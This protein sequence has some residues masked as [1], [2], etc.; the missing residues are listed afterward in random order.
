MSIDLSASFD[1][2]SLEDLESLA[3]VISMEAIS[4]SSLTFDAKRRFDQFMTRAGIF[5]KSVQIPIINQIKLMSNDMN[6][7]VAH[8]GFMEASGKE[9]I[10]PEGFVGQWLPYSSALKDAMIKAAKGEELV[11]GFNKTLGRL[12]N[13]PEE[14]KALSGIGHTGAVSLGLDDAMRAIGSTYFDGRSNH[15]TRTLGA[16]VERA[17]DIPT[18]HSNI[19]DA[20]ALDK[21]HPA[22]KVLDAVNRS[23]V[24][25]ESIIPYTH[26]TGAVSKVCL[27]EMIDITLQIAREMEAYGVL[28]FRIRQFSEALKDSVQALKK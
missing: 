4:G 21:A 7:L 9:V 14:L 16:V 15:I 22:K 18:V 20:I 12:I 1:T 23:M 8:F 26:Q 2:A 17:A 11:L 28:L 6:S 27:Q 3:R 19:N 5:F 13:N 24:L 25:S 10:V